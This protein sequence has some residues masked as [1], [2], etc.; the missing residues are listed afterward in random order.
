MPFSVILNGC[1]TAVRESDY[2]VRERLGIPSSDF[3]YVFVGNINPNKN[4]K[5]V[6]RAFRLL[7][8]QIQ[9]RTAIIFVGGGDVEDL[10]SY[11]RLQGL[12]GRIK[13]TG[14]VPKDEVHNYY[15]AS[16]ATIL[17]SLSE[18]FGLSIIEGYVYG[19]PALIFSDL[20]AF[21]DICDVNT[22]VGISERSDESLATG[23]LVCMDKSWDKEYIANFS[24]RFSFDCMAS[25]YLDL[26][27]RI[28]ER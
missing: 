11:V 24:K 17:T 9:N 6:V 21:A 19:K 16:D 25:N 1:D 26:F 12:A 28:L 23:M 10:K 27:Q 2:N 13:V 4:Q 20:S 22:A 5:Q 8:R 18:G 15:I 7:P 14:S 3:V